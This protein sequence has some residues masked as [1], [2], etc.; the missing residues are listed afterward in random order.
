MQDSD[1]HTPLINYF[2]AVLL[3]YSNKNTEVLMEMCK[4]LQSHI[5]TS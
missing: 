2:E 1:E 3:S 5:S 4:Y